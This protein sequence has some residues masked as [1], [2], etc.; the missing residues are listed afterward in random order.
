M[1]VRVCCSN[2]QQGSRQGGRR[3]GSEGLSLHPLTS[4]SDSPNPITPTIV[5]GGSPALRFVQPYPLACLSPGGRPQVWQDPADPVRSGQIHP[6]DMEGNR[7][8]TWGISGS[9]S[10]L[11]QTLAELTTKCVQGRWCVFPIPGPTDPGFQYNSLAGG[12]RGNPRYRCRVGH[13]GWGAG[14]RLQQQWVARLKGQEGQLLPPLHL[15]LP[16][17]RYKGKP[18][19]LGRQSAAVPLS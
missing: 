2:F 15:K 8:C 12:R 19:L 7:A 10:M 17:R 13:S 6:V 4:G 5:T 1:A 14:Q 3:D 18:G 16:R 11:L 9:S